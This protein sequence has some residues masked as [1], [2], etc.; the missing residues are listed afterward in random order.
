V[1]VSSLGANPRARN[2]YLK[3]K[4]ET[5]QHLAMMSFTQ[6]TVI[7]PSF[8]DD[9]GAR[10]EH[11]PLE[12]LSL[13]LLRAL[14]LFAKTSRYAP[15]PVDTLARAVVALAFDGTQAPFRIVEG[16]DIHD[17]ARGP[18]R[19]RVERRVVSP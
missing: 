10:T 7:R 13:P 18:H 9:R 16:R 8:I 2:F 12:R 4:G 5:E 14:F 3:T 11:R 6:L 15:I 17:A 1:L 19:L